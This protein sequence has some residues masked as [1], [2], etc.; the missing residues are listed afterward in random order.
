MAFKYTERKSAKAK[1]RAGKSFVPSGKKPP[2]GQGGRFDALKG[3]LAKKGATNPAALAAWI[4]RRKYGK[5]KFAQLSAAGRKRK[6]TSLRSQMRKNPG[7]VAERLE[8][9]IGFEH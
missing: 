3:A 5:G 2:L 9:K 8:K 6:R 7:K 1:K 4:G